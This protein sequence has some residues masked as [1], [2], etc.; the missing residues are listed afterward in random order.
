MSPCNKTS[1]VVGANRMGLPKP[2]LPTYTSPPSYVT[3]GW[4]QQGED[5]RVTISGNSVRQMTPIVEDLPPHDDTQ[6]Q[7]FSLVEP[8]N[9]HSPDTLPS[10][11]VILAWESGNNLYSSNSSSGS[12]A[13]VSRPRAPGIVANEPF[14]APPGCEIYRRSMSQSRS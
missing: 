14:G 12:M 3:D 6:L 13:S 4:V 8:N 1:R 10:R 5:D 11:E 2:D 9:I 7:E